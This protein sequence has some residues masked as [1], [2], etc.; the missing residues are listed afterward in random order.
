MNPQH[1]EREADTILVRMQV[2]YL[3]IIPF[4][5]SSALYLRLLAWALA[6]WRLRFA[7][8]WIMSRFEYRT[9][10]AATLSSQFRANEIG[11]GKVQP[12]DIGCKSVLNNFVNGKR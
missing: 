12:R 6:F 9:G 3:G 7:G 8:H 4:R 11:M 5:T 2:L 1:R 10:K